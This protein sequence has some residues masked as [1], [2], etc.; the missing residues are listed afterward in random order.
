[1][2]KDITCNYKVL[3]DNENYYITEDGRLYSLYSKKF[4]KG[5]IMTNGY[6]RYTISKDNVTFRCY[7][8]RLV[9]EYFIE[10][11][12]PKKF[13]IV[14]HKDLNKLNNHKDN[15]EWTDVQGNT[16]HAANNNKL[17]QKRPRE[18]YEKDLDGESW[19]EILN[20]PN[21]QISS[22][23]RIKNQ[24]NLLLKF[25]KRGTNDYNLVTLR[26]E[27]G[28]KNFT[29]HVLEYYIFNPQ[30]E[31]NKDY[32]IDHIDGNKQNN[33]LDNLRRITQKENVKHSYYSQKTN[34]RKN[35]VKAYLK[36]TNE[37]IGEYESYNEAGRQLN[38]DARLIR[39]VCIKEI[40]QTH[41][42]YF[43]KVD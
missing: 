7:A 38:I 32:V 42:Y 6:L 28:K 25:F 11:P 43:E 31:Q 8:H 21:Y 3:K 19:K 36:N 41:G 17:C 4:L 9:A 18:Y 1:M 14:N 12:D 20:Y 30:E 23:G 27:N 22:C 40:S 24:N 16:Q 37:F 35:K 13:N 10:N 15:L 2:C 34:S 29:V 39:R 33:N 26:N 5:Q